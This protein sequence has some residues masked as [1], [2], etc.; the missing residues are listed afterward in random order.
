MNNARKIK[1]K[2]K[3]KE[4]MAKYQVIDNII[5]EGDYSKATIEINNVF[6][7]AKKNKF[8]TIVKW[9]DEKVIEVK[10]LKIIKEAE[11]KYEQGELE[12]AKELFR[13][14]M[15]ICSKK[16]WTDGLEYAENMVEK[17]EVEAPKKFENLIRK[18]KE[19]VNKG[20]QCILKESFNKAVDHW[21]EALNYYKFALTTVDNS[22][23]RIRIE[24]NVIIIKES[25]SKTYI[26]IGKKHDTIARNAHEDE[27][28]L[29]AE[30]EW[31]SAERNIQLAID[32]IKKEKLE[33][34]YENIKV[35]LEPIRINLE[36]I[37]I[38]KICVEADKKIQ[39]ARS[40]ENKDLTEA[41][42]IPQDSISL[43]SEAKK[44]AEERPEFQEILNRIRSRM[45]NVRKFQSEL[46]AKEDE[47]LEISMYTS[48]EI[49]DVNGTNYNVV[50][51][52]IKPEKGGELVSITREYEFI[53]G[54]IRFKV[55]LKNNTRTPLT[56]FKIN[57]T[58]PDALKW[59]THV[60]NYVR[61]GDSILIPKI[62]KE[63]KKVISL[64]LEPINCMESPINATVIFSDAKDN[65]QAI[66]MKPKMISISCPMF[67]TEE[68]VNL[69]R[70]K[71]LHLKLSHRDIKVFPIKNPKN[72]SI[73]Y[74]L[75]VSTLE[76]H[77][78]KLIFKVFSEKDKF[79]EAWYYGLTKKTEN[80]VITHIK[81]NSKDK[82]LEFEV[83]G[84]NEEQITSF[85]AE[86]GNELRQQLIKKKI[87]SSEDNFYDINVSV[88]NCE[89]PFCVEPFSVGLVQKFNEGKSIKCKSCG[90]E[91][92][93]AE[94]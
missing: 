94:I 5:K 11:Q 25:I 35:I 31:L 52:I 10:N 90:T 92:I 73:L 4:L 1:Y 72:T 82:L 70:V 78:I 62:G 32:L 88:L 54:Q 81:L 74:E 12:H 15:R 27:N 55:A 69:A 67:F 56:V 93:R 91:I 83:S 9:V 79:G 44:K 21:K 2:N 59:T 8:T 89:C 18:A 22:E 57:F 63:E 3:K 75:I 23:E 51:T 20:N 41:I 53:G 76:N 65:P 34:P 66:T 17:I 33:I 77:H 80:R 7:E 43:Y 58:I 48:G 45:I 6:L 26:K 68:S 28:I 29:I 19:F 16:G 50:G 84:D 47:L 49:I 71:N 14:S 60:P 38:E 46:R 24:N 87:I 13:E 40:L 85:L 61:K 36:Q 39:E 42:K 64:Y 30:R 86:I 37:E